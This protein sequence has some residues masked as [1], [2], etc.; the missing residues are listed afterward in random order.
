MYTKTIFNLIFIILIFNACQVENSQKVANNKTTKDSIADTENIVDRPNV[1][2][3][4]VSHFQG[5]L[6]WQ[7]L[8]SIGLVFAIC[9]ATEG[10]TYQDPDLTKNWKGIHSTKLSGGAYHFFMSNDDPNKQVS[11]FTTALGSIK[12]TDLAPILDLEAGGLVGII[13]TVKYQ[14]NVLIWLKAIEEYYG[15]TPIVYTNPNFANM[16][17]NFEAIGEYPLWIAQYGVDEPQLPKAWRN[18][19]WVFWQ[20]KQTGTLHGAHGEA[21]DH[22]EFNGNLEAF[23]TF[24]GLK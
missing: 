12:E 9:K 15:K 8:D 11:N 17:L 5:D 7:E 24:L 2:G 10:I 19:A 18:K 16:Y 4:D 1:K 23:N 6:N 3:I 14:Q 21:L 22:D 13:D 20:N